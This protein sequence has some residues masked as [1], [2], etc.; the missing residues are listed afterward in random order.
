MDDSETPTFENATGHDIWRIP[1]LTADQVRAL[2]AVFPLAY[3]ARAWGMGY[4]RAVKGAKL[5]V[6]GKP[7][8]LPFRV[9]RLG[10]R[11]YT[12]RRADLMESLGIEDRPTSVAAPAGAAETAA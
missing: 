3:A 5:A 10:A 9:F 2:P 11:R 4:A 12:V 1:P 6:D 8:A 7:D